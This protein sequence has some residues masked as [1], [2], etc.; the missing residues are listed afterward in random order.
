MFSTL[1][2]DPADP[3]GQS[4]RALGLMNRL[5]AGLGGKTYTESGIIPA[6]EDQIEPGKRTQWARVC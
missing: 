6:T 5:A 1:L 2:Y 3:K 4:E